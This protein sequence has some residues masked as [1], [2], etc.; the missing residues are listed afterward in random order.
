MTKKTRDSAA[1]APQ[2]EAP[3]AGSSK[4]AK[5]LAAACKQLLE[6]GQRQLDSVELRDALLDLHHLRVEEDAARKLR[7]GLCNRQ[8]LTLD[9]SVCFRLRDEPIFHCLCKEFLFF[10]SV[11]VIDADDP[12]IRAED[13]R[14]SSSVICGYRELVGFRL[15]HVENTSDLLLSPAEH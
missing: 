2:W 5:D 15:L 8:K 9:P 12:I 14:I 13:Q 1:G 3:A 7:R 6:G 10:T 4:P 11:L